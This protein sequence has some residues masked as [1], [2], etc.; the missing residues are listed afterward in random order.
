MIR[1]ALFRQDQAEEVSRLIRRT[2]DEF[3]AP[4]YPEEGNK[5]FYTFITPG[6]LF[7]GFSRSGHF[8][9]TAA[10]EGG[11]IVGVIAVRDYNHVALMFVDRKYQGRGISRE[12]L[13]R[14]E[15][16]IAAE[17]DKRE[18]TVFS[19]P[20]AVPIYRRLGFHEVGPVQSRDG[21]TFQP[22]KHP[23]H[24]DYK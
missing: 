12:L 16:R 18:T 23:I 20:Y 10:G 11:R 13:K 19:S 15:H 21:I 3:V 22:M 24:I 1:I 8:V 2:Y 9:L 5:N 4:G 7:E 17:T 14:A 6:A